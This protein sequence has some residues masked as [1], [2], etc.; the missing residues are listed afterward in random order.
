MPRDQRHA[1]SDECELRQVHQHR[2]HLAAGRGYARRPTKR[3]P[4]DAER[5]RRARR[6]T[7][8]RRR[9]PRER[10]VDDDERAP[11]PLAV[12]WVASAPRRD[13]QR[14]TGAAVGGAIRRVGEE[15]AIDRPDIDDA[16]GDGRR[17]DLLVEMRGPE[18]PARPAARR[19]AGLERTG[20]GAD[21][22]VQRALWH[23]EWHV[24]QK[25]R[26]YTLFISRSR[27]TRPRNDRTS[28]RVGARPP[29][30]VVISG[31]WAS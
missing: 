29:C 28:P 17:S 30:V 9:R 27:P 26:S 20:R 25:C 4:T 10:A 14:R 31:G 21:P 19:T 7:G 5:P 22:T 24:E 15:V 18:R 1:E 12:R 6:H 3:L 23:P 11:D 2:S 8:C 13:P 16:V